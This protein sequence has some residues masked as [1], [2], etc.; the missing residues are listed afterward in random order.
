MV[1]STHG[2]LKGFSLERWAQGGS[3]SLLPSPTQK[4]P[5]KAGGLFGP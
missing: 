4:T 3:A 1:A 2:I 5:G